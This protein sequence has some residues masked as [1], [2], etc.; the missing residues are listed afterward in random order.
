MPTK[1]VATKI[2][3]MIGFTVNGCS[4]TVSEISSLPLVKDDNF[5]VFRIEAI[6]IQ[7]KI[8]VTMMSGII[9]T[10]IAI[11]PFKGR[12]DLFFT[13]IQIQLRFHKNKVVVTVLFE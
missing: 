12:M 7:L 10:L 4:S 11:P 9:H 5:V 6:V 3:Q 8:N 2:I 1:T 13:N